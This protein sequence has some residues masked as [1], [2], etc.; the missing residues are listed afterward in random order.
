MNGFNLSDITDAKLGATTLGS[1]YLGSTK[2]WPL[3]T[4]YSK[5]TFTIEAL[6]SACE[7]RLS[8]VGTWADPYTISYSTNG[9]ASWTQAAWGSSS[10]ALKISLSLGDTLMIRGN[11]GCLATDTS[12][13]HKIS[14][15]KKIKV[16][17]NIN[18][19]AQA[20][21]TH[22]G[23]VISLR[24][25]Y[26][27][28]YLFSGCNTL[29][30]ASDLVLPSTPGRYSYWAMFENCTQLVY[31]PKTLS[32]TEVGYYGCSY[33]FSGCTS[34]T[35]V[36]DLPATTLAG[37]A[38]AGMFQNCTSLAVL[39]K[40][41]H[42][43]TITYWAPF[44]SMFSSC[45]A[46]EDARWDK[47]GGRLL[48]DHLT[49]TSG[50][51]AYELMFNGCTGLIYAP[52]LTET[53]PHTGE[54]NQMFAYC[55]NSSFLNIYTHATSLGTNYFGGVVKGTGHSGNI[56]RAADV[57][58]DSAQYSQFN[59][60]GSGTSASRWTIRSGGYNSGDYQT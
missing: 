17:G 31:P 20:A 54:Y 44:R 7:I 58:W 55:T 10:S 48:P 28:A 56:R 43:T 40:L 53:S 42:I 34:L 24:T 8:Q 59:Y 49:V 32:G 25:D 41:N 50:G 6:E 19:L 47:Y 3:G 1:I 21:T 30:D 60:T 52:E 27:Y 15:T 29:V 5:V 46:I 14:A 36:P 2:L 45:K 13:Y 26:Y 33:M 51:S 37:Y 9:G 11:N 23:T 16:Y 35:D 12:N 22:G 18:Y 4:D 57:T 38:Y 39:P